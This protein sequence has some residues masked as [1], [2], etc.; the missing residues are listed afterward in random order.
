M[1]FSHASDNEL[2]LFDGSLGGVDVV[3]DDA[4][5]TQD[6]D[7]VND[8]EDVVDIMGDKDAGVA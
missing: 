8:L 6:Y 3:G 4:A 1:L 5:V 7:A 2:D